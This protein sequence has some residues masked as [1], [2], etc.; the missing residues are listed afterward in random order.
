MKE[1]ILFKVPGH[2]SSQPVVI[3]GR[4]TAGSQCSTSFGS[5]LSHTL[6]S[7]WNWMKCKCTPRRI[8]SALFSAKA[9]TAVAVIAITL[10]WVHNI[11]MPSADAAAHAVGIDFL[12]AS[13]W[14]I[15]W[16]FRFSRMLEKEGGEV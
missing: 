5:V 3:L 11:V 15:V 2:A 13:P 14:A 16:A 10:M 12:C 4:M 9:S 7:V 1:T 8:F 6:C